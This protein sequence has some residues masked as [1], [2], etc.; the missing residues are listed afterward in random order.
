MKGIIHDIILRF[1]S[2]FSK[3]NE[4]SADKYK[5]GGDGMKTIQLMNGENKNI[6]A[7]SNPISTN[8]KRHSQDTKGK[9]VIYAGN[10]NLMDDKITQRKLQARKDAMKVITDQFAKDSK[11]SSS[12]KEK[13][14]QLKALQSEIGAANDRIK[15][16]S[17]EEAKLKDLYHISDGS[18]E[19]KDLELLLKERNSAESL[20]AEEREYLEQMPPLTEYQERA[21]A[22]EDDKKFYQN[23]IDAAKSQI[24]A[25]RKEIYSTQ[26]ALLATPEYKGMGG[27]MDEADAILEAAGKEIIGM[28]LDEGKEYMEEKMEEQI[29]AAKEKAEKE[30]EEEEKLE[31]IKEEKEKYAPENISK[32]SGESAADTS[33]Q[34]SG[35]ENEQSKIESELQKI[36][37]DQVI[38]KDDLKG[39]VVDHPC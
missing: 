32:E 38:L 15:E 22:Y 30:K 6:F 37:E 10:L 31:K 21:L 16:I 18:K 2:I 8:G 24:R 1:H 33:A 7:A 27:A 12:I 23:Q 25:G 3:I 28:L 9:N 20:T 14:E 5:K 17:Q 19:Q 4:I 13:Q 34:L 11:T 39:L 26:Q 29:E 36:I 35:L